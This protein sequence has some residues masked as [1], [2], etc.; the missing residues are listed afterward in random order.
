MT[1]VNPIKKN[2]IHAA[3]YTA[4][5]NTEFHVA[6]AY[7]PQLFSKQ[8]K[9]V[10]PGTGELKVALEDGPKVG[11]FLDLIEAK[12][13]GV[14]HTAALDHE[15][16]VVTVTVD[17]VNFTNNGDLQELLSDLAKY[18]FKTVCRLIVYGVLEINAKNY[19]K[20]LTDY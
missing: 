14:S 7:W 10:D 15:R 12:V 2:A 5:I 20:M 16:L 8:T 11:R 6:P 19:A 4:A 17:G 9:T 18:S 13:D 1:K 3:D